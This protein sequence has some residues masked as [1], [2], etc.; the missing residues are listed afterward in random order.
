MKKRFLIEKPMMVK[1]IP[2]LILFVLVAGC[3]NEH[4]AKGHKLYSRFC[5]PC[6][7]ENGNGAGY[8]AANLDPQPRD[9]T[10]SQEEYM[11]KLSNDEIYEVLQLGGYGVDLA[12][13][14]PVWGK[15]FSEEELW[16]IIAYIRTLHPNQTEGI[17]FTKPDSK[18]PV[19][20]K[21]KPQYSRVREKV[22]Y[23]LMESLAPDEG[24]FDEQVALGQEVFEER[25]C[26]GCHV[27]NGEG[28]TL[29]PDLSKAGSMLQTQFVFRWVLNPQSFKQKTRMP[30]LD[31]SEEDAFAVSL[32]VS[33]LKE[34]VSED[35]D[36]EDVSPDQG[37]DAEDEEDI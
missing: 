18:E 19:F 21:K 32:Y 23:D 15:V 37:D 20:D 16:S 31:L 30:N 29:G 3:E 6:H 28:G 22:F 8:N 7:G 36:R 10:D 5:S 33:T 27:V 25:G 11:A 9:L 2:L 14:M 35:K 13:T 24:T 34:G 1:A 26:I 17:V 12:G 4:I